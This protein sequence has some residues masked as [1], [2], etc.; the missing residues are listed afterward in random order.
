MKPLKSGIETTNNDT[1]II[2]VNTY[3]FIINHILVSLT[4][5]H[6]SLHPY[7]SQSEQISK[8]KKKYIIS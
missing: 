6:Q 3:L 4:F 7:A 8:K 1:E 5:H 2:L